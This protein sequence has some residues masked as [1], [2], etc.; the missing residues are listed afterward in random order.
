[1]ANQFSSAGQR[2]RP[3]AGPYVHIARV[4]A[5][6]LDSAFTLPGTSI[7]IGLDPLI[8]LIPGF[9]D[10]LAGLLGAS[11]L[12][13]GAQ[14]GLPRIVLARMSLNVFLNAAIGVI[15]GIGDL[16]SFWFKSNLRNL[17]L[18]QRYTTEPRRVSTTTD[19]IFVIGMISLMLAFFVLMILGTLW[20]VRRA[21]DFVAY[22]G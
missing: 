14:L 5:T 16:F 17:A 1:M 19:W 9:G 2:R 21:W 12:F 6:L 22:S 11:L 13:L 18:I 3:A 7:R 4:I 15:P 10:T 8:G 20:L